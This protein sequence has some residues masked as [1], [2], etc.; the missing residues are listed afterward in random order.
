MDTINQPAQ[1]RTAQRLPHRPHEEERARH[2]CGGQQARSLRPGQLPALCKRGGQPRAVGRAGEPPGKQHAA[3]LPRDA[4][5][6]AQR[7]GQGREQAEH[8]ALQ[9]KRGQH[10]KRQERGQHRVRP[11]G[12]PLPHALHRG[13][14]IEKEQR[15]KRAQHHPLDQFAQPL[16]HAQPPFPRTSSAIYEKRRRHYAGATP[17]PR[18]GPRGRR[19]P[20]P[21]AHRRAAGAGKARPCAGPHRRHEHGRAGGRRVRLR[22]E[23]AAH[24]ALLLL[25]RRK[26]PGR[27][28]PAHGGDHR[29]QPRRAPGAHAH[30]EQDLCP[31]P[32]PL[33]GRGHGPGARRARRAQRGPRLPGHPR[34]D[35]HPR[36]L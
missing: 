33:C 8:S 22:H 27:R 9:Q 15:K 10:E 35:L 14:R 20:R 5:Q 12:E 34:L 2:R 24:G 17:S 18:R 21:G 28:R 16:A 11:E 3:R 29:R 30:R 13:L 4:E 1:R 31:D 36:H 6:A 23:S 26:G 32:D 19:L 7:R 25:H